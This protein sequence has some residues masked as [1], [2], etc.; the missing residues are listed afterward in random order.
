MRNSEISR[1]LYVIAIYEDMNDDFFKARAYEKAARTIDSLTEEVSEI[2]KRGGKDGLRKIPGVG[3]AI[4]QK[5][6]DLIET[7]KT[8]HLEKLKK[9]VPVDVEGMY[10]LDGVGPKTIKALWK[11]LKIRNVAQLEKAAKSHRIMRLKG[12]GE[13]SE[14]DILRSIE[15]QRKHSGRFL[16]GEVLPLLE[17]IEARLRRVPGVKKVV[18]CGSA[19][20]MRETIGD[21]DFLVASDDLRKVMDFFEKMPEVIHVYSRGKAKVLVKLDNGM[22][23]DLEAVPERS[24]GAAAQYFT[25]STQHNVELRKIAISKGWKLNE[26]GIFKGEKY[27]YGR[28]EEEV[29]EKLGLQFISPE[30]RE[31]RGEIELAKKNKIPELIPYNSLRGDLHTHS[32]WTDGMNTIEEMAR[33]AKEAGLEYIAITDHSQSLAMANGLD[34]QRA[35]AHAA[36]IRA[37]DAALN[38]EGVGIRLLAGIE[39][40]IRPDGSMDLADDCLAALD[41]VVASVHSAFNQD[42]QQMTDRL[43]G[44]IDNPHV[45]IIG[46][47]TGRRILKRDAYAVDMP[48]VIDA[49]ARAGV[50]LEI[51]A[52][53]SRLDLNDTHARLA[54]DRG[55]RLVISS[56]AHSRQA[57]A[58]LRWG[59][60][61]ARRAWLEA[62]HVLNT[63]PLDGFLAALRRNRS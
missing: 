60:L 61:V 20:R 53:I 22:D 58:T 35:L 29:Y 44:A 52:Q 14:Q 39:C 3:E 32:K 31:N 30:M 24:F 15:F 17:D 55:V 62:S 38:A 63:R 41:L 46:H 7:G 4:S 16:I 47:P 26:Y 18:I 33:A 57:F 13:K 11:S 59:V 34:E 21:A 50:A 49:A 9:K 36:R 51:N 25:G 6:A 48:R 42:R 54:R 45:D 8:E 2:Y 28:D 19:R 5:I 1:V 10:E 56:D 40:D 23:A 37:L 27:L 43:L 12:F